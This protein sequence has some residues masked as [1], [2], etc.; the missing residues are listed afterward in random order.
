MAEKSQPERCQRPDK[1]QQLPRSLAEAHGY[2]RELTSLQWACAAGLFL[3]SCGFHLL[4]YGLVNDHFDRIARGR[5][6]AQ[7]GELPF[8][9]FFDPGYFL[10]LFSSAA[11]QGLFGDNLLGEALLNVLCFSVGFVLT[12]VLLIRITR[13]LPTAAVVTALVIAAGPRFYDYDKVLFYPLGI[14]LCWRYIDRTSPRDLIMLALGTAVAFWFRYDN[15]IYIAC[16]AGVS[17]LVVHWGSRVTLAQRLGLYGAVVVVASLPCLMFLQ[18]NGGVLEYVH[19]ITSYAKREGRRT[20]VFRLPR[21]EIDKSAPLAMISPPRPAGYPI[22]VR[23]VDGVSDAERSELEQRFSL[24][25]PEY[26]GERTWSYRLENISAEHVRGL[27][28]DPSIEDTTSID[29]STA[30]VTVSE[31]LGDKLQRF[32]PILRVRVLPGMVSR[33]NGVVFLYYLFVAIPCLA[34]M[35]VWWNTVRHREELQWRPDTA[36]VLSLAAMCVLIEAFIL[37]DPVS[38]RIGAVAPPIAILGA[39]I[40]VNV[41]ARQPYGTHVATTAARAAESGGWVSRMLT[42]H[43]VWALSRL[44]VLTSLCIGAITVWGNRLSNSRVTPTLFAERL[45]EL[46]VS[47]PSE[48]LLPTGRL[49]GLGQYAKACTGPNDRILATWFVP[50]LYSYAA[51]GFAGG[52]VVFFGG[53][54]SETPF[55]QRILSRLRHQ[56]V[57]I[58]FIEMATYDDFRHAY[59]LID[60]Y[61]RA[62]YRIAGESNLGNP[63][64]GEHGYRVMVRKELTP[65]RTYERWQLPCFQ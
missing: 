65:S 7:Y 62:N 55:Q 50:E 25:N 11:V 52:M 23:W 59:E 14:F 45:K 44:I 60:D 5:Q 12:F 58:V 8:R 24:V 46:A 15:G 13:S 51:R 41:G 64:T 28:E 47:P 42:A 2:T 36:R 33:D 32:V 17:L 49:A 3:A 53:H 22:T 35:V 20:A 63:D 61:L 30:R 29:R 21:L 40:V 37:R 1:S 10:T 16:A 38:A 9:D 27:I 43:R 4:T 34:V 26:D 57:P 6:I 54:W 56:S 39:W 48:K 31:P 19:Q 18:V